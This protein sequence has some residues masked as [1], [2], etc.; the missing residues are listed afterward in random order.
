MVISV[1]KKLNNNFSNQSQSENPVTNKTKTTIAISLLHSHHLK[2]TVVFIP[3]KVVASLLFRTTP[4]L[5]T[6]NGT[7]KTQEVTNQ[8]RTAQKLNKFNTQLLQEQKLKF[9]LQK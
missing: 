1:L 9:S 3:N 8:R 5:L 7:C 4:L 6:N 2:L